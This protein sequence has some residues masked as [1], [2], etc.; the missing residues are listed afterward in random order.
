MGLLDNSIN[1]HGQQLPS[2]LRGL[3][4]PLH[5][6]RIRDPMKWMPKRGNYEKQ[7]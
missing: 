6:L 7:N 4:D 2:E 1:G 3:Q 5:L